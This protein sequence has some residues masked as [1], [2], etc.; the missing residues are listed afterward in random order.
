M[1]LSREERK[2]LH[3]KSK[4]PTFGHG[5]PEDS[6]GKDGD[7]SFRQIEGSGTVEYQIING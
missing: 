3:Q 6:D 2:L 1:P 5:K 4:Q 7:I